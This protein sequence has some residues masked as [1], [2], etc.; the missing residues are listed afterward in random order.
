[1]VCNDILDIKFMYYI[2][3]E[4]IFKFRLCMVD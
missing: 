4:E 2:V 1:M 3:I